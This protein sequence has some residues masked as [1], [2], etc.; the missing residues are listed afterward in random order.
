MHVGWLD[1]GGIDG[2]MDRWM[3]GDGWMDDEW[4]DGGWMDDG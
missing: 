4:T 3:L 2:W 1:D